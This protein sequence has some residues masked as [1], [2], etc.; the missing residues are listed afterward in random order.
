MNVSHSSWRLPLEIA[1][2][3]YGTFD[4]DFEIKKALVYK[5]FEGMLFVIFWIAFLLPIFPQFCFYLQ[6]SLKIAFW[7]CDH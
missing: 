5:I 1:I 7:C 6:Y 3:I 4:N 2:S